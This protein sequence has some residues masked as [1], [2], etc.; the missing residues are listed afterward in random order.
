MQ[1]ETEGEVIESKNCKYVLE[2]PEI[3]KGAFSIVYRTREPSNPRLAVKRLRPAVDAEQTD[4]LRRE[5]K[6]LC[7]VRGH[8]N[9]IEIAD[10]DEK[11]IAMEYAPTTLTEIAKTHIKG[12]DLSRR[13]QIKGYF[14]QLLRGL[15]YCH[16][17]SVVHRDL[18]PDNVLVNNLCV[19][20]IADFGNA[21]RV[22][23]SRVRQ[24]KQARTPYVSMWYRAPELLLCLPFYSYPIDLWSAGCILGELLYGGNAIF[25]GAR[26]DRMS[27]LDKVWHVRGMPDLSEFEADHHEIVSASMARTHTRVPLA[28]LRY[29]MMKTPL[30]TP[31]A[32]DL[33]E[34]ALHPIASKRTSA[35]QLLE[36]PYLKTDRPLPFTPAE[37][38][39]SR[40]GIPR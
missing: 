39:M 18:K 3:G 34:V 1:T 15:E 38:C 28:M 5:R 32:A 10:Y 36:M 7:Q 11:W 37:L 4:V 22:G 14:L 40:F 27:Q 17:Q 8:I 12:S 33:L 9:V 21:A 23:P 20:K 29:I 13:G 26:P 25:V 35:A 19:V 31:G 2:L 24:R 16:A 30:C 6:L